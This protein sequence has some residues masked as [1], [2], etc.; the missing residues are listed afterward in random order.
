M[1]AVFGPAVLVSSIG[2]GI[3]ASP[4]ARR[5]MRLI[6]ANWSIRSVSF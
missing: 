1:S 6:A 3:E 2:I 5:Q 4:V